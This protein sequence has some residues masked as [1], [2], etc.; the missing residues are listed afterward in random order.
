MIKEFSLYPFEWRDIF[1]FRILGLTK[2]YLEFYISNRKRK[3]NT[4]ALRSELV[5]LF[6]ADP[7]EVYIVD[8]SKEP[9]GI[10]FLLAI[11]NTITPKERDI[12]EIFL[13]ATTT[14]DSNLIE[15][16]PIH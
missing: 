2:I 16:I 10:Y 13:Q 6:E 8:V 3:W 15:Y 4:L 1:T 11:E 7:S 9:D 12:S 5:K 14:T